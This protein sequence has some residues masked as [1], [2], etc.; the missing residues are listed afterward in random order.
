MTNRKAAYFV[1]YPSRI[2]DLRTPHLISRE[3]PYAVAREI[4]L[5]AIDYENFVTDIVADRQFLED[6]AALC[7]EGNPMKCL[8]IHQRGKHNGVLAIPDP[9]HTCFARWAAYVAAAE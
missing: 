8:F 7:S 5:A 2:E 4:I 6:N 1:R 3:L 9:K